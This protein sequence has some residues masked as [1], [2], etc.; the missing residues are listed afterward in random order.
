[1]ADKK[2][3]RARIFTKTID[4]V[5]HVQRAYL[6]ADAVRFEYDGWKEQTEPDTAP[7]STK[8]AKADA[9]TSR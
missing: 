5:Q 1:M 9:K 2:P 6:P 7:S 8:T 3:I 4:G